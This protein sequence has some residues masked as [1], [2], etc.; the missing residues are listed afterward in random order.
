MTAPAQVLQDIELALAHA[1]PALGART[2][3]EL[4]RE[5]A[6][7]RRAFAHVDDVVVIGIAGGT[8][9]G[10]STLINALAGAVITPASVARPT[11]D[12]VTIYRHEALDYPTGLAAG[13]CPFQERRHA[14]EDLRKVVILD[15]PDCDSIRADHRRTLEL[16]LPETDLLLLVT[17]PHKYGDRAFHDLVQAAAHARENK[18]VVFNKIDALAELYAGRGGEVLADLLADLDAKLRAGGA[19]ADAMRVLPLSAR[20]ALDAKTSGDASPAAFA[21]LEET[22]RELRAEKLRR[23]IKERNLQAAFARLCA[24]ARREADA[25]R[26]APRIDACRDAVAEAARELDLAARAVCEGAFPQR[27][28]PALTRMIA[29]RS[30][31]AWSGPARLIARALTARGRTELPEPGIINERVKA[32]MHRAERAETRL[33]RTFE[34]RWER[35]PELPAAA[36]HAPPWDYG[37]RLEAL[38][39]PPRRKRFFWVVCIAVLIMLLCAFRPALLDLLAQLD[40]GASFAAMLRALLLGGARGLLGL[41]HPL[42]LVLWAGIIAC[43]YA[44]AVAGAVFRASQRAERV[45]DAL[46]ASLRTTLGAA[47]SERCVPYDAHLADLAAR[48]EVLR[49]ALPRADR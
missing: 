34:E 8:G 3:D 24:R 31:E 33:R 38:A 46:S 36:P 43:A 40:D 11:S 15:L 14:R 25:A 23:R 39:G 7:L 30:A 17:D 22:I 1:A 27:L 28:L 42:V 35:A 29:R 6:E 12:R 37:E 4:R 47:A 18:I 41:L 48:L 45:L 19:A 2:A 13:R 32:F 16:V 10:K 49:A 20:E 5:A 9:V 44:A 21:A 26:F